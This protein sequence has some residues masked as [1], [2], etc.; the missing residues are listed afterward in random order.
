MFQNE[1]DLNENNRINTSVIC[2][3]CCKQ[4]NRR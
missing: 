1:F 4:I 2:A 3:I